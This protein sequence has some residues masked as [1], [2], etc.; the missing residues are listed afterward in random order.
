MVSAFTMTYVEEAIG[1]SAAAKSSGVPVAISFTLET[2]GK[3]PSGES[4]V[5]AIERTD[6]ATQ[7]YPAYYMVNCAHPTHFVHVLRGAGAWRDRIR[8]LRANASRLSHGEL[9]ASTE[10]DDGDPIELGAQYRAM[11]CMLPRLS[12][13]GGCCGTDH[14]HV[15]AICRALAA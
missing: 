1:I 11:Q 14:R 15:D 4:L 2:D 13:V 7:G 6:E 8:G 12:V 9:D 10:L 3:L 5:R